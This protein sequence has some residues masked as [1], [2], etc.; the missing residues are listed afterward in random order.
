MTKKDLG[1]KGEEIA[2]RF[3]ED[4]GFVV[5]D[6]NF[7]SHFGEIDLIAIDKDTLVFV[8]VK[9]RFSEKFGLPEEAVTPTKI[10]TIVKV[11]DYYKSLHNDLPG[12]ERIDVVAI[13]L[14]LDGK[15]KRIELISNV[16][17]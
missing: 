5:I 4:A 3:L 7:H 1:K 12:L 2:K 14:E 17:G 16:T 13:D 11:G 9:T 6:E 10:K 8:E 15:L